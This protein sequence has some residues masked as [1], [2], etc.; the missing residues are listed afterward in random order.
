MT[1]AY[2]KGQT[3]AKKPYKMPMKPMKPGKKGC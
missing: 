3:M 1:A 2:N